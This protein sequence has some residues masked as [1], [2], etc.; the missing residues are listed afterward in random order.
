[1]GVDPL[2]GSGRM[3]TRAG[4]RGERHEVIR[5]G[6]ILYWRDLAEVTEEKYAPTSKGRVWFPKSCAQHP[7]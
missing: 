7:V 5:D 6:F 3:F 4:R 1:M 2:S